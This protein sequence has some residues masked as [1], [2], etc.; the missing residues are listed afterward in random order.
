[1][2][3]FYQ[4]NYYGNSLNHNNKI[5]NLNDLHNLK[6]LAYGG[7][8]STPVL[9]FDGPSGI[10]GGSASSPI[11]NIEIAGLEIIGPNESITWSKAMENRI[12][13]RTH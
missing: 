6:I 9:E 10:F 1:M 4:N 13:K 12:V 5:V 8:T 3:G 7:N 2:E 11:S